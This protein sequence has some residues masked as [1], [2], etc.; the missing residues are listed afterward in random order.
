M[1]DI[2]DT[3]TDAA[4]NFYPSQAE[5]ASC[6][7]SDAFPCKEDVIVLVSM[8]IAASGLGLLMVLFLMKKVSQV[9]V[10]FEWLP[11]WNSD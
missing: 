11:K 2:I 7:N 10:R 8:G 3:I 5:A 4:T 6:R 9:R 1:E